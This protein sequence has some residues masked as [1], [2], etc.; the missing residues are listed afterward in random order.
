MGAYEVGLMLGLSIIVAI[1][2]QNMFLIRQG[3]LNQHP[4]FSAL[5]CFL[6]DT[7]LMVL[8]VMGLGL[9]VFKVPFIQ[10][11]VLV[12]ATGF[13]LIYGAGCF[14]RGLKPKRQ[15]VNFYDKQHV[16]QWRVVI[17]AMTFSLLN[18]QAILDAMVLIGGSANQYVGQDRFYFLLGSLSS[19]LIW[20]IGL[21]TVAKKFSR[22]LLKPRV[23]QCMEL[24][25]GSLMWGVLWMLFQKL[26]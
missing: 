23:W 2:A 16:S 21:V 7:V 26:T 1:G 8:G 14:Y 10:K 12:G 22:Y 25:S 13:L 24:I 18:P 19:S 17:L 11:M 4:F 5:I 3:V 20:F 6:C 15:L 9:V